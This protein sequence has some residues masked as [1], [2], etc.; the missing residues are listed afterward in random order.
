MTDNCSIIS[1]ED[2]SKCES[3][4]DEIYLE[5]DY[6]SIKSRLDS[7]QSN[8]HQKYELSLSMI[9]SIDILASELLKK[10]EAINV[11]DDELIIVP[12]TKR[13]R[14]GEIQKIKKIKKVRFLL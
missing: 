11:S 10:N 3:Y 2:I 12:L 8:L 7:R 5:N 13:A 1:I 6:K 4:L 9:N 14:I